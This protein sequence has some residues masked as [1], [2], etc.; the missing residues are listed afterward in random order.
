MEKAPILVTVFD[1][2]NHFR[3]CIESL[4]K[5]QEANDTVLYISSDGPVDSVSASKILA[6]REYIKSITGFK[7][8]IS[9][10]PKDNTNSEI[11]LKALDEVRTNHTRYIQTED[12]NIFSSMALSYFNRGL[13]IYEDNNK[14]IAVSGYMYPGF[15]AEHYDQVFLQSVA[16]WGVGLWR[17]RDLSSYFDEIALSREVL[18]NKELFQKVS[19]TLPNAPPIIKAISEGRLTAGDVTRSIFAIKHNKYSVHPSISLVRNIGHD[20]SGEHCGVSDIYSLQE[21]CH[22]Q[23]VFNLSKPIQVSY[24]DR[25]WIFAFMGGWFAQLHGWLLFL[26]INSANPITH[27][28]YQALLKAYGLVYRIRKLLWN[29]NY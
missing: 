20:G 10:L 19:R 28:L 8:I 26:K 24:S 9:F 13:D 16:C 14:I 6:V 7:R 17:D 23:I 22:S 4:A 12:D 15:P 25:K 11:K 18:S 29:T 21:I 5:N 3:A 2:P 27:L 1:R